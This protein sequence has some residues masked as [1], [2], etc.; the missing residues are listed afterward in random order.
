MVLSKKKLENILNL[1]KMKIYQ[2]L[3]D[4]SK[5]ML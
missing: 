2:N 3:R 1:M 4:A 5:A